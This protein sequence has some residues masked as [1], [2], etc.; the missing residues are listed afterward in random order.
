[1]EKWLNSWSVGLNAQLSD[2]ER[3]NEAGFRGIE[4]LAEQGKAA[5]YLVYAH[6]TG[7]NLGLHLPFHDLNLATPDPVVYERTFSI[8]T[9]WI[10]RLADYGGTHATFH[11]GYAWFSEEKQECLERVAER[12]LRL[13]EVAKPCGV[14]LLLENLIPD[15]LNYCHQVASNL[16]EW[17]ELIHN[18][19]V[20]ACLD[21]G[22]LNLMGHELEDTINRLGTSLGAMHLSENDGKADLH[23]L[24]GDG[25][26]F[27][28]DAGEYLTSH[29]FAGPVIY[30][31]N[32]YKYS[33][34]QIIDHQ[35][36]TKS[37][38][39]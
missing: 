15:H 27:T 20:K 39:T 21:T 16:N 23:L 4:V 19:Q 10:K 32:P 2:F 35:S 36:N 33:L 14:D 26:H 3:L 7:F 22:H 38:L 28:K 25:N 8:L 17:L 12:I 11:G 34:Q 9:D 13:D 5:D 24:P 31:I 29:Q 18:T 37:V 1:M 30:E 6:R